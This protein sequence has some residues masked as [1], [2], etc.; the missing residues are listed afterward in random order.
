[1]E[2]LIPERVAS[3]REEEED[4][5][6][7]DDDVCRGGFR[8]WQEVVAARDIIFGDSVGVRRGTHGILVGNFTD[9]VHVT[10][11]FDEREDQSELCVNVLPEALIEPLPGGFRLGQRIVALFD[12]TLH[13]VIG[14]RLGTV[15]TIVGPLPDDRLM[16][17]FDERWDNGEGTVSVSFR[18]V[19]VQRPLVGG[20]RISQQVQA[21]LNLV[22]GNKTVVK[23]GTRGT[24]LSEFSDTRLT[25]VFERSEEGT[26]ACFNVMPLEIRP[27]CEVPQ[28]LPVGCHV[29]VVTDLVSSNSLV[30]R[31]GTKGVILSGVTET[32]VMANFEIQDADSPSMMLIVP[33]TSVEIAEE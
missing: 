13:G 3:R 12:L 9:A 29:K 23:A 31:A 30:V 19:T 6:I 4:D 5:K 20:F 2:Q 7:V 16:V 32:E 1:M 17:S 8:V 27:W 10:V 33:V 18:E 25:V 21:S 24:V 26:Q 15:G 14:V 11:R 28:D 22:V